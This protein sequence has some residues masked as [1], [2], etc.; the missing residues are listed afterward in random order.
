MVALGRISKFL[1]AEE[2]SDVYSIDYE[3]K[4]AVDVDGDFTWETV[5]RLEEPKFTGGHGGPKNGPGKKGKPN[6]KAK[7]PKDGELPT[8]SKDIAEG[9]PGS[10]TPTGSEKEEEKPFEL[11]NLKFSVPRGSFVAIVGRV[12]SG[13]VW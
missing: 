12:G 4:F 3:R 6:K 2:M 10:Q 11:K 7:K 5:G 13:K 1:L 9:S 8:S